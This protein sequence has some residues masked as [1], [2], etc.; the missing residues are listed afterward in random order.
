M[1][2]VAMT[3][4]TAKTHRINFMLFLPVKLKVVVCFSIS[5]LHNV[6]VHRVAVNSIDF[7]KTRDP[8]LR[9]E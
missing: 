6:D 4:K 2:A 8:R 3:A 9:G 5:V 7:K 1:P